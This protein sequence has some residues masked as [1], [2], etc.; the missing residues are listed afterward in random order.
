MGRGGG[1]G[2]IEGGERERKKRDRK[3]RGRADMTFIVHFTD[4]VV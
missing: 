1:E 3:M 4:V 2:R